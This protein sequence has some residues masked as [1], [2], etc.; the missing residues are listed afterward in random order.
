MRTQVRGLDPEDV[1]NMFTQCVLSSVFIMWPDPVKVTNMFTQ[2]VLRS[3]FSH[4]VVI[5]HVRCC[6]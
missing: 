4:V 3:F 6:I 1:L 5:L 2:C